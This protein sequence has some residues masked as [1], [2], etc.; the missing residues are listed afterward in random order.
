MPI[1]EKSPFHSLTLILLAT[2]RQS[3]GPS[4]GSSLDKFSSARK[5]ASGNHSQAFDVLVEQCSKFR[6]N[7][8][9]I[10][11][12]SHHRKRTNVTNSIFEASGEYHDCRAQSFIT[13][14]PSPVVR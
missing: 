7:Q 11:V 12:L 9:R 10:I 3:G 8:P 14:W 4:V 13:L 5:F 2:L 6:E 1:G